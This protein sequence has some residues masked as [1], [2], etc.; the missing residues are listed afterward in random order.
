MRVVTIRN[1]P[2]AHQRDRRSSISIDFRSIR[3][4]SRLESRFPGQSASRATT[5]SLNRYRDSGRIC[6]ERIADEL[7]VSWQWGGGAPGGTASEV[8]TEGE[9][10][11]ETKSGNEVKK[12]ADPENPAVRVE[13]SGHD[14]VKR[15]SELDVEEEGPKHKDGEDKKDEGEKNGEEKNGEEKDEAKSDEKKDGEEKKDDKEDKK[16]DKEEKA[17][18]GDASTGDKR[19]AEDGKKDDKADGEKGEKAEEPKENGD[20]PPPKKKGRPAKNSNAPKAEKPKKE[21]K[22]AATETGEPRRSGRNRS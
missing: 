15:A 14:V 22:K 1:W 10:K 20:Q 8:A 17:T 12:N 19:K 2:N 3:V 21:P 4:L 13:R 5:S 18:N 6:K 7:A 9:L 11:M 16:D